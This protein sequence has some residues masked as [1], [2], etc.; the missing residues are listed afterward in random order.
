M[1]RSG[2]N[3]SLK[4]DL[5]RV[6]A[7]AEVDEVAGMLDRLWATG[8]FFIRKAPCTGLV[9]YTVRDSFDVPFH[10]GEVLIT[11]AEATVEGQTGRGAVCGDEPEKALLL[12]AVEAAELSGRMEILNDIRNFII[13][14]DKRFTEQRIRSSKIAAATQVRFDSMKKETIDFASLGE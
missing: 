1:D 14:L 5:L 3:A 11:T 6:I 2:T 13:R 12:A 10:L 7:I 9:M 4:S 8:A